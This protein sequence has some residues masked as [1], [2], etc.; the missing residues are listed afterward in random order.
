MAPPDNI[1]RKD[2]PPEAQRHAPSDDAPLIDPALA[3]TLA[4]D[5]RSPLTVINLSAEMLCACKDEARQQRYAQAIA[6]QARAISWALENL[7]TLA[8]DRAWG[9]GSMVPVNLR[10]AAERSVQDVE[11]TA[12]ARQIAVNL[13]PGEAV[14]V[15]GSTD[16]LHQA[17][18]GCLQAVLMAAP[19]GEELTVELGEQTPAQE[20]DVV[21]RIAARG[22]DAADGKRGLPWHRLSFRAA[23]HLVA[24]HGGEVVA[25]E[26]G[27]GVTIRL[28]RKAAFCGEKAA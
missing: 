4:H 8:D 12:A 14:W 27:V 13:V 25:D 18:R 6:E 2:G 23:A 28:P 26:K 9:S 24:C 21:V 7:L 3:H 19:A 1:P 16:A 17:L 11:G 5:L 20:G 22:G 10:A 15:E